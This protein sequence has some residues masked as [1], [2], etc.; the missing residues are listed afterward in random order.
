MYKTTLALACLLFGCTEGQASRK[1]LMPVRAPAV[2]IAPPLRVSAQLDNVFVAAGSESEMMVRVRVTTSPGLRVPRA[3]VNLGLVVDTSGSMAGAA[4]EHARKAAIAMLDK[5]ASGD[6][7]AVVTF[8]SRAAVIVPSTVIGPR[9]RARIRAQLLAIRARGTT[10]LAGGL[11]RGIAQVRQFAGREAISRIVLLSDG[12]PNDASGVEGLAT[13]AQQAGITVTA[14][15]LGLDYNETL[16]ASIA[17]RSGGSFHF[18]DD[19]SK[20]ADVFT[21]EVIRMRHVVAQQL[22][23]RV[24]PGPGVRIVRAYGR[25]AVRQ[26][27]GMVIPLGSLGAGETLDVMVRLVASKHRAGSTIELLDGQVSYSTKAGGGP[28]RMEKHELYVSARATSDEAELRRARNASFVVAVARAQAA[29]GIL[30]AIAAARAT[31]LRRANAILDKALAAVRA[32]AKEYQ[33]AELVRQARDMAKLRAAL[34][35]LVPRGTTYKI[36]AESAPAD[37]A[38]TVRSAHSEATKVLAR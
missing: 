11:G 10:D 28:V 18:I 9:T 26:G 25:A 37:A 16:L 4:I 24:L 32:A 31:D 6:R 8:N 17:R 2:R 1:P 33:D 22:A 14:L 30:D 15:G 19:A 23:L 29:Q 34:P 7:L 5:L 12:N 36:R 21:G 3:P 35:S 38:A 27:R 20:V 13:Q